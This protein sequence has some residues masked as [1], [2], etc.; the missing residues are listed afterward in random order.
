VT[1]SGSWA[2]RGNASPEEL[3]AVVAV[4]SAQ[5]A[6][7]AEEEPEVVSRWAARQDHLRQPL[8]HGPGAWRAGVH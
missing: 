6:A 5:P 7:V 4:L 3:A 8:P 1:S 2:V